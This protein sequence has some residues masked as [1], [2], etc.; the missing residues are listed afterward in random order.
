MNEDEARRLLTLPITQIQ[1]R[2]MEKNKTAAVTA[3]QMTLLLALEKAGKNRKGMKDWLELGISMNAP[4]GEYYLTYQHKVS[5]WKSALQKYIRRGMTEKALGAGKV[6]FRMAQEQA[7]RRMKIIITEDVFSAVEALRF[8]DGMMGLDDFLSIVKTVADAPKDKS[9]C[10]VADKLAVSDSSWLMANSEQL[11]GYLEAKTKSDIVCAEIMGLVWQK[12]WGRIQNILGN[13]PVV[14]QCIQ[15]ASE[16]TYFKGDTIVLMVAAIRYLYGEHLLKNLKLSLVDADSV[17]D[18]RLSEIDWF[19]TDFHTP[20]GR[21]VL[22]E[23]LIRH[24]GIDRRELETSWFFSESAKLSDN[25]V[26]GTCEKGQFNRELWISYGKEI[27][28]MVK[29]Y[30]LSRFKI[31]QYD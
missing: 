11:R 5:I 30:L 6:L 4:P 9:C 31:A 7:V 17:A 2:I 29:E 21:V 8:F 1:R 14:R 23:F 13:D 19:C 25:Q 15:R 22:D 28:G 12:E 10:A 20:V 24:R 3:D 26:A 18:M 16:G 27:E